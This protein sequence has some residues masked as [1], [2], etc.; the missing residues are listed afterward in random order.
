MKFKKKP[1]VI[2][3]IQFWY[4]DRGIAEL[5]EFCGSELKAYG[6]ARHMLAVGWA[7]VGTLEDGDATTGQVKHV[8]TEGDW[9]IR[10]VKG[11]I[12]ACKPDIFELTYERLSDE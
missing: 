6:K 8:A 4:N 11:E 3:A 9:I 12:Y 2:E 5:K 10:G 7:H 1:V